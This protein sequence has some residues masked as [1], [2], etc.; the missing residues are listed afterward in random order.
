MRGHTITRSAGERLAALLRRDR[1][2]PPKRDHNTRP[3]PGGNSGGVRFCTLLED[4]PAG[5]GNYAWAESS[6]WDGTTIGNIKLYNWGDPKDPAKV[7]LDQVRAGFWMSAE[8]HDGRWRF[9]NGQCP[10]YCY[11]DGD[12]E[13]PRTAEASVGEP[14]TMSAAG[15]EVSPGS[16]GASGVD[17]L[18][19]DPETGLLSGTPTAAGKELAVVTASAARIGGSGA[20]TCVITRAMEI[21]VSE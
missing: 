1:Y 10:K 5:H 2:Q 18:T 4:M 8:F 7:I 13:L 11:T 6:R 9:E 17:W 21:A 15:F 19:V 20:A 14:F 16:Y 3:V 12:I